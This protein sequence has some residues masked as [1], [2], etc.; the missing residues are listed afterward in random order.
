[1][2]PSC[3]VAPGMGIG[4][5]YVPMNPMYPTVGAAVVTPGIGVGLGGGLYGDDEVIIFTTT[6]ILTNLLAFKRK[7]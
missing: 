3:Y 5:A 1:M 2:I 6:P 4:S 7:K